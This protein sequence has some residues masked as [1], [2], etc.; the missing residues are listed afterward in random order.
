MVNTAALPRSVT[1]LVTTYVVLAL[2]TLLVLA[3]LSAV[4]PAEAGSDAWVH[5]VVVAV[6]AGVLPLRLRA[7]RRGSRRAEVALLVIAGVLAAAN[8]V[9]A[10]VPGAFPGWMRVEMLGIAAVMVAVLVVCL[11]NPRIRTRAAK[12]LRWHPGSG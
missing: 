4:A 11:R 3:V 2:G 12:M 5:A 1:P 9:E 6:F 7:A 10:I 8:F